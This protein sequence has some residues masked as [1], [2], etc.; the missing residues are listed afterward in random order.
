VNYTLGAY[1]RSRH[2]DGVVRKKVARLDEKSH[3]ANRVDG[4]KCA[5]QIVIDGA[6]RIQPIIRIYG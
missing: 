4:A 3:G 2:I 5:G 6:T 1:I